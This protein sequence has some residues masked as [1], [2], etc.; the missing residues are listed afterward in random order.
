MKKPTVEDFLAAFRDKQITP[1]D[2][3]HVHVVDGKYAAR[4]YGGRK[5]GCAITALMDG[6]PASGQDSSQ[7]P[8][9][10]SLI[11]DFQAKTGL[12]SWAFTDG[13]DNNWGRTGDLA[14]ASALGISLRQA[15]RTA[16]IDVIRLT[17]DDT[18]EDD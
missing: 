5:C 16:G 18:N 11:L 4:V 3:F 12:D 8:R 17:L 7:I 15:L 1:A 2:N 13:F 9:L 14:E 6:E 10:R